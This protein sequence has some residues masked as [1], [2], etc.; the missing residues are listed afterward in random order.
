MKDEAKTQARLIGELEVMR[1][2]IAVLEAERKQAE[3][4]SLHERD[5]FQTLFENHP[6]FIYFKNREARFCRVSKR[7][8]DF[9]GRSME[10]IIGRT[11]LDLFPEDVSR[12]THSE[13]L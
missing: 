5:L 9:F 12:Q 3:Q 10:D 11:D 7:F 6:D 8:C 4:E 1:G 13:D 2:R